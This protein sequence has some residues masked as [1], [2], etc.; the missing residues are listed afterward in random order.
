MGSVECIFGTAVDCFQV[1]AFGVS[2]KDL[3]KGM[4]LLERK[5]NFVDWELSR[6]E[7]V[8]IYYD[9]A[10]LFGGLLKG[11][12]IEDST[13]AQGCPF[14]KKHK[15]ICSMDLCHCQLL[16]TDSLVNRRQGSDNSDVEKIKNI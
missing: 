3:L 7:D 5:L 4:L 1:Q 15:C 14:S 10:E 13:A 12:S 6:A 8:E 2:L 11:S 16:S 9:P